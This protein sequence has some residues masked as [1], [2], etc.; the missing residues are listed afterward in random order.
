[1]PVLPTPDYRP[2]HLFRLGNF[3]TLYP[4]LFRPV[5]KHIVPARERIDTPDGD[6]LELDRHRSPEEQSKRLVIIS[7]GLEGNARK[8][9]TIGMANMAL[10]LGFD[11]ACWDQRGAGKRPNRKVRSYHSGLTED[12][13]TVISHCLTGEYEEVAL[14]GFSMG[15][16]QILKYLGEDPERV[17]SQIKCAVTFSVPCDLSATEKVIARPTRH[18]YFQYF[19]KGLRQKVRTKAELFP[20][21]VSAKKLKGIWTLRDFDDRYTAPNNGFTD[22]EDYYTQSSSLQFLPAIKVPTLLV[23]AKDDPFLAPECFPITEAEANPNLYLEMPK[24]GGH[25]GFHLPGRNNVYWSEKRAATFL[26]EVLN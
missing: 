23:Q 3:A 22:A 19:M 11:A 4:S 25:V 15:G 13:H 21:Q 5:P 2:P 14:I 6:Y 12:L 10:N 7:H 24:Y 26:S 17:P 9:Y 16:N 1:M 18:I 20:G 8:K